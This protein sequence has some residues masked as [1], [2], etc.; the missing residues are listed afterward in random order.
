VRWWVDHIERRLPCNAVE[1]LVIALVAGL[2]AASLWIVSGPLVGIVDGA[3]S[4]IIRRMHESI[5][6]AMLGAAVAG[7]VA[8]A[9]L[10]A[11]DVKWVHD[12]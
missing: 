10:E 1:A 4:P 6:A 8:G 5:A 12:L 3:Y 7:A 9:L 2:V 11:F